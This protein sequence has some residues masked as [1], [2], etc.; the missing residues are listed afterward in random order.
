MTRYY[1]FILAIIVI[2]STSISFAAD[3]DLIPGFN[4][5]I[6][7]ENGKM[8]SDQAN[9]CNCFFLKEMFFRTLKNCS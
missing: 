8:G 1:Y 2:L 7:Y 5:T 9:F 3:Q 4:L 6:L